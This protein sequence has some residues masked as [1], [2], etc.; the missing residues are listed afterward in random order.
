MLDILGS[1]LLVYEFKKYKSTKTCLMSSNFK[2]NSNKNKEAKFC[3][4]IMRSIYDL[5]MQ[6]YK[7]FRENLPLI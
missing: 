6:Q 7:I 2:L 4:K 3:I 1:Q 5:G